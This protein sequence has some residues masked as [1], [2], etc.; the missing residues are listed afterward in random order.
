ML[1]LLVRG[2]VVLCGTGRAIQYCTVTVTARS[3][4]DHAGSRRSRKM[5]KKRSIGG[6]IANRVATDEDALLETD[7]RAHLIVQGAP[8]LAMRPPACLP[9]CQCQ[10]QCRQWTVMVVSS[11]AQTT[12]MEHPAILPDK[13]KQVSGS[14][15]NQ[16]ACHNKM[17][18][19]AHSCHS[20]Q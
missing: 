4:H 1:L 13:G 6:Q 17:I 15:T 20:D 19:F 11:R 5:G 9:A 2:T 10:C 18:D 14:C 7:R 12:T 16:S 3:H 8:P